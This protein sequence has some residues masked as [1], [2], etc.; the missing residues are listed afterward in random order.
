VKP[1]LLNNKE[2]LI[3]KEKLWM[4]KVLLDKNILLLKKK[5]KELK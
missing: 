4:K 5:N 1:F 3:K 2:Y